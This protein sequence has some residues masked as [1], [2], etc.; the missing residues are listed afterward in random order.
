V[1]EACPKDAGRQ[2]ALLHVLLGNRAAAARLLAAAPGLGWSG[3][4]H[5]GRLLFPLFRALLGGKATGLVGADG[6]VGAI[7]R[8]SGGEM[9]HDAL[10]ALPASSDEPRLATPPLDQILGLADAGQPAR[11]RACTTRRSPTRGGLHTGDSTGQLDTSGCATRPY[12]V[13]GSA[14]GGW[15]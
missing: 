6:L 15:E 1:L 5:P 11:R 12:I 3:S 4:E 8:Q 9:D 2:R 14:R 13:S 10:D 7:D